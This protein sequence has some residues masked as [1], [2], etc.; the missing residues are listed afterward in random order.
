MQLFKHSACLEQ[1]WAF[2]LDFILSLVK[3]IISYFIT[4]DDWELLFPNGV[5]QLGVCLQGKEITLPFA[6]LSDMGGS[7]KC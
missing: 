3:I 6:V 2:K 7:C 5:L 4:E 1:V